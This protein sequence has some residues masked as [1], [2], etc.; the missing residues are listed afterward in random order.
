[1]RRVGRQHFSIFL[2]GLR[3]H[4]LIR[5][6]LRGIEQTVLLVGGHAR[7]VLRRWHRRHGRHRLTDLH[8]EL[9]QFR[10]G[11]PVSESAEGLQD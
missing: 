4:A 3:A 2:V 7:P 10:G 6:N 1:M 9:V 5:E 8:V 11:L